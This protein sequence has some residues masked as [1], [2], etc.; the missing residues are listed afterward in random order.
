MANFH[1]NKNPN[2]IEEWNSNATVSIVVILICENGLN[3]L[4][5]HPLHSM[6][7][8][9]PSQ[10][11]RSDLLLHIQNRIVV[12][13]I[14]LPIHRFHRGRNLFEIGK[15]KKKK[16]TLNMNQLHWFRGIV[17]WIEVKAWL[18]DY[19]YNVQCSCT[20]MLGIHNANWI[21]ASW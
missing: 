14:L 13:Y 6:I 17:S 12:L 1:K 4:N 5:S 11:Y 7:H 16:K 9:I 20:N 18:M 10:R 19:H 8:K 2:L 15:R 21:N 3:W